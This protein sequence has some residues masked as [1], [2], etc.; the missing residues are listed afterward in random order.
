MLGGKIISPKEKQLLLSLAQH[1][2]LLLLKGSELE[3]REG[4]QTGLGLG[5]RLGL[6][7]VCFPKCAS[8]HAAR[9]DLG[10]LRRGT[11]G[12]GLKI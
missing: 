1:Q 12:A 7:S 6:S 10:Q 5:W 4:Q 8:C 9:G 11:R 2:P 3:E